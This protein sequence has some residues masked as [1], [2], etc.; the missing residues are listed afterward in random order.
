MKPLW[1]EDPTP[2]CS[3]RSTAWSGE[4]NFEGDRYVL[5]ETRT[6]AE[7]ARAVKITPPRLETRLGPM[8]SRL[9]AVRDKRPA[10]L[11]DDKVLTG[12]NGL[13]IAAYADGYRV[14]K[15]AKY[16][17]PPRKP[18]HSTREAAFTRWPACYG[19][20]VETKPSCRLTSRITHFYVRPLETAH[21]DRR[22][23]L[24]EGSQS[25]VERMIADFEDR[26]EGGFFFTADGHESLLAHAKDPFD[27][28]LPGGNSMAILD[29]ME[30]YRETGDASY[31][32]H[33]GKALDAFSTSLAQVPAAMPAV[34]I[35]LEQY[36]DSRPGKAAVSTTIPGAPAK[37]RERLSRQKYA[38]PTVRQPP[39]HPAL[40]SL[41]S[42][43]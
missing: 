15:V 33:A 6:R 1:R 19:P 30:L 3:P 41:R 22:R 23:T 8:R 12:W 2:T 27:N 21:R 31:R 14:L 18:R 42:S 17:R 35:G 39:S 38:W 5:H 26:E 16:V 24:V 9:L 40:S 37:R 4:P 11:C 13:M 7:Q 43:R 34:V 29:L 25:L 28:A 20:F 32:D 36:L 10:P